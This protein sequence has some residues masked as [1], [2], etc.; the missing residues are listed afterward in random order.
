LRH[1]GVDY[2]YQG[3]TITPGERLPASFE[4]LR[5]RSAALAGLDTNDLAQTLASRYPPRA[6]IGWHRDAPMFGSKIVG[7]SLLSESR[8][9]PRLRPREGVAG[10][11]F[12]LELEP[13]SAY[14]LEGAARSDWEHSISPT[15]TLRYSLTFRTL[16]R[17]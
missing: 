5:E 16:K 15:R 10:E 12:A 6:G 9:R 4:W 17:S 13:R 11:T 3:G 7:V 2:D 14:V 1:F 8:L